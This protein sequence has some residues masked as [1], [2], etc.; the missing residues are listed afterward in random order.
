MK[1]RVLEPFT[2][3]EL[4]ALAVDD[5]RAVTPEQAASLRFFP[6]VEF[7]GGKNIE[8]KPEPVGNIETKPEPQAVTV[9]K[10][11]KKKAK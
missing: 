5:E 9:K 11:V 6:F 7:I 8:T 1:I 10:S 3:D 4:G 2:H